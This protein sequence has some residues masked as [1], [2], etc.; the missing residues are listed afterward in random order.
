MFISRKFSCCLSHIIACISCKHL[1]L[2]SADFSVPGKKFS[3]Y[4][5]RVFAS[6]SCKRTGQYRADF[7]T[8]FNGH[9]PASMLDYKVPILSIVFRKRNETLRVIYHVFLRRIS[10]Q[11]TI[12]G[13]ILTEIFLKIY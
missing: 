9:C 7:S 6:V 2:C 11:H 10:T 12:L 8:H 4:L 3:C 13:F 1:R 5:S